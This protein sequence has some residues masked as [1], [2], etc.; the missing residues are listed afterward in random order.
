V[1]LLGEQRDRIKALEAK[2]SKVDDLE[3]ILTDIAKRVQL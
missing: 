1:E 2:A 3:R